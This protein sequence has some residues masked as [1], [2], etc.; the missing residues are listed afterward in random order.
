MKF[1]EKISYLENSTSKILGKNKTFL[2]VSL[3][4]V[5]KKENVQTQKIH[6]S[7]KKEGEKCVSLSLL[8]ANSANLRA[9]LFRDH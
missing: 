6:W 2:T 8:K 9:C 5:Y 7:E 1:S 4:K 3:T